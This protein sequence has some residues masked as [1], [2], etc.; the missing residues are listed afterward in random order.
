MKYSHQTVDGIKAIFFDAGGTLIHLDDACI[1]EL[2]K[3]EF[4]I[5][6]SRDRFARAQ[7]LGMTEVARLVAEGKG[8]TEQLKRQ[9]YAVSVR[10][11]RCSGENLKPR[12]PPRSPN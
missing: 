9:F 3:S 1:C 8:S 12:P 11:P 10:G 2:I 5:E 7:H 4:G 6:A